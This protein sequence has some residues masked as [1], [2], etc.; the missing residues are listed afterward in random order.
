MF[1]WQFRKAL[2]VAEKY[3]WTRFVYM[4]NHLNLIYREDERQH[5]LFGAPGSNLSPRGSGCYWL[6]GGSP[7]SSTSS[8]Q[9][10]PVLG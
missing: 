1:A 7:L 4:Q 10:R 8:Q 2:H 6:F 9:A 3:G 5:L